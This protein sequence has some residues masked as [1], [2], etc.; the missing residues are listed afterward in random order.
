MT[1]FPPSLPFCARIS[2][3]GTRGNMFSLAVW[4]TTL[5][6]EFLLLLRAF[7]GELLKKYYL[8]YI[9]LACVFLQ[10]FSLLIIYLVWPESYRAFYWYAEFV[11]VVLGCG[12]VLA[13]YREALR[14]FPGAA[15]MARNVL[16]FI[17]L[18]A[19][20]KGLVNTWNGT[21]WWPS[22][23]VV[24][25]ERDL[26]AVQAALL[27]GFV[28]VIALYRIPLGGNLRGILLGYGLFISSNVVVLALR[29]FL[30]DSFQT[31]WRYLQPLSYLVVLCVWCTTLWS[32]K[33]IP[34]PETEPR[35]EHDYQ[36]LA[37]AT[38]AGLRHAR[39]SLG[40]AIRP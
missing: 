5:A 13:V 36:L 6:L 14:L 17:L 33:A 8:F 1:H 11:S 2:P 28:I 37:A 31:A 23:T 22:G 30:G 39:A 21:L 4:L 27:I 7:L 9:Y 3:L 38:R 12:V 20:S 24:A 19:V 35:I 18:M 15:R 10:S 29:V 26:R 16:L 34:V 32:Y 25:L 40:R